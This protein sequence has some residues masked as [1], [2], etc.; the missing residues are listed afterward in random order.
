MIS[1]STS[2]TYLLLRRNRARSS[3]TRTHEGVGSIGND[4]GNERKIWVYH[5]KDRFS[6]YYVFGGMQLMRLQLLVLIPMVRLFR[7]LRNTNFKRL[8][9]HS[10]LIF[11][12][13]HFVLYV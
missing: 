13:L 6:N 7:H 11:C 1:K 9:I 5:V 4:E 2:T 10:D 12:L 8:R 3:K